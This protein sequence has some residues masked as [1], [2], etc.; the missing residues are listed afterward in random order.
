MICLPAD[1]PHQKAHRHGHHDELRHRLRP[2][3]AGKAECPVENEQ[4]RHVQHQ[5]T[6]HRDAEC[7][8]RLAHRL[9]RHAAHRH[10]PDE[11]QDPHHRPQHFRSC[12]DDLRRLREQ[13]DPE[14]R[15]EPVD[16]HDAQF[17]AA[18]NE[19]A[20]LQHREHPAKV[21]GSVVV[22]HD[23]LRPRRKP[24]VDVVPEREDLLRHTH[25]RHGQFPVRDGEVVVDD[26]GRR[27][28]ER[29][30][31]CRHADPVDFAEDVFR[32]LKESPGRP[33]QRLS[34]RI[35]QQRHAKTRRVAE[36]RRDGRPA[37]LHAKGENEQRLEHDV[38][39][40]AEH[41]PDD[42]ILRRALAAQKLP[43]RVIAHCEQRAGQ[44]NAGVLLREGHRVFLRAEPRRDLRQ[45]KKA[46]P[47]H[48]GAVD[49]REHKAGRERVARLV[50][51][52]RAHA[53]GDERRAAGPDHVRDG[54]HHHHHR[55]GEVHRRELV[56]VVQK[57]YEKRIDQVVQHH[58]A[59]ARDE[60]H[61]H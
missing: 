19:Y 31:R 14:R 2:D 1:R 27:G 53:P 51:I 17:R 22:A 56:V 44:Q 45:Q 35:Q 12:R 50:H 8:L 13:P 4:Q 54:D 34:A 28:K 57:A 47:G 42:R 18:D 7:V 55:I 48:D 52:A 10:R 32:W 59:H 30:Q 9:E 61:A 24:L 40:C 36:D 21:P 29:F 43:D 5:L 16:E 15:K 25:G 33:Q 38:D 37:D 26:V 23:R 20:R 39:H 49:H 3:H 6:H 46:R 41:H 11:R 58:D 60:R